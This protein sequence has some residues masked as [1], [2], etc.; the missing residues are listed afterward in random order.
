MSRPQKSHKGANGAH[1]NDSGRVCCP[2]ICPPLV[3]MSARRTVMGLSTRTPGASRAIRAR[4]R[5]G[6]T[7]SLSHPLNTSH[8]S[9]LPSRRADFSSESGVTGSG[10][11]GPVAGC[12]D[13]ESDCDPVPTLPRY[14]TLANRKATIAFP[15]ST[16]DLRRRSTRTR[17]P[18]GGRTGRIHRHL[19][20]G[21]PNSAPSARG[22]V[23][24]LELEIASDSAFPWVRS[25]Q[26][27]TEAEDRLRPTRRRS[28]SSLQPPLSGK[29]E[30]TRHKRSRLRSAVNSAGAVR[31]T[32]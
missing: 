9:G 16:S 19:I 2:G 11:G 31:A 17:L 22:R 21:Q 23:L 30:A 26:L 15:R 20:S 14:A 5:L 6:S 13:G 28:G 25:G 7:T 4:A 1:R 10:S 24:R 27:G 8:A 29:A 3:P 18:Q 32:A 12:H